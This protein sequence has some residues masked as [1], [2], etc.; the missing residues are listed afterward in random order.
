MGL[1]FLAYFF[2]ADMTKLYSQYDLVFYLNFEGFIFLKKRF[3]I[4]AR[5]I[6]FK[7]RQSKNYVWVAMVNVSYSYIFSLVCYWY[8]K[9]FWNTYFGVAPCDY[10]NMSSRISISK[11]NKRY[12]VTNKK[13]FDL[14]APRLNWPIIK[15]V[16][17]Y[18]VVLFTIYTVKTWNSVKE[19]L[20][21]LD[22]DGE[23][24]ILQIMQ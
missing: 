11:L 16:F 20:F 12:T 8:P 1:N 13:N 10:F 7:C 14:Q 24:W 18:V 19:N 9:P 6:H 17:Y 23:I 3:F 2:S 4:Q 22:R 15:D 21:T 5:Q